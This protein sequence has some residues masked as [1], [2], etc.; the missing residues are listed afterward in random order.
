MVQFHNLW[1]SYVFRE[2]KNGILDENR[3]TGTGKCLLSSKLVVP[4]LLLIVILLSFYVQ[5]KVIMVKLL[6]C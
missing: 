3:L 2:Y 1:F 4:W 5:E 6:F